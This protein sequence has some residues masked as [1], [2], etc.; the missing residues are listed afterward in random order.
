MLYHEGEYYLAATTWGTTLSMKHGATIAELQAAEP[1]VLW[2]GE[3]DA[4]SRCCNMWAPEFH[5][6]DGPN[7]LR[8]YMYYTAGDGNDL[9]TQ[10]SHVLESEGT[11]PMGPYHFAGTLYPGMWAI[12]GSILEHDE[13]RYFLF[14]SGWGGLQSVLIAP[15]SNPW[16]ISGERVPITTP[17]LPW[18]QEG[19][20]PVNEGPE[21]LIHDGRT[22]VVFSASHCA[23]PGYKLG[24]AE[25][26]GS[27]PLDPGDWTTYPDPVF[28]QVDGVYGPAHNGF[29]M[30]PDGTENWIVYHANDDPG[31]GC[32]VWR[33]SRIQP[34]GW[35]DAGLP[36]FGAPLPLSSEL[37]VP[38]GE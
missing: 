18:E 16:T 38:S 2:D 34:F 22:F 33:T 25:L 20:F 31:A 32:W 24:L 6:L 27:D 4:P 29:F 28:E 13:Q 10:R 15:M 14:S 7:G 8:W 17:T 21:P 35:S 12:D 1:E 23:S 19:D 9:G 11:D 26:T 5:L 30:S 36:D 37:V 3:L